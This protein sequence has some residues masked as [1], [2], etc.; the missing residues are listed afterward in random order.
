MEVENTISLDSQKI[1]AEVCLQIDSGLGL[2]PFFVDFFPGT[3]RI[4]C[5]KDLT[6]F[7]IGEIIEVDVIE[8][9][10]ADGNAYLYCN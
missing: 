8:M 2:R 1:L 10:K 5:D 4:E 9:S 7:M 3:M 6:V